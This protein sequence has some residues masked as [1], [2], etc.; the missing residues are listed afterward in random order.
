MKGAVAV[1]IEIMS[2]LDK[3]AP[4]IA[5]LLVDDEESSGGKST[6]EIIKNTKIKPL[7]TIVGEQ[8]DFNMVIKQKGT[9][10]ISVVSR[11][12]SAHGAEPQKGINAITQL[13]DVLE[14]IGNWPIFQKTTEY[15]PTCVISTI[16]GGEATN[17]VPCQ[18]KATINIRYTKNKEVKAIMAKI[19]NIKS[20]KISVYVKLKPCMT[21]EIDNKFIRKLKIITQKQLKKNVNFV[22]SSTGSDAKYFSQ[23]GLPVVVFGPVGKNY[24]AERE[25]VKINSLQKYYSILN[26]FIYGKPYDKR[27]NNKT[28]GD[29]R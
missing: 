26:S 22:A 21:T 27:P 13:T 29:N 11:G 12:K 1:M 24:H 16:Q 28:S 20:P 9:I 7:L 10:S 17:S 23:A 2:N 5:L 18:A 3:T 15:K 19:K 6:C 14:K 25:W 8:T 4:P